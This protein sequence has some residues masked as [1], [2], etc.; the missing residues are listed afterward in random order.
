M[1]TL[2]YNKIRQVEGYLELA[3]M[4]TGKNKERMLHYA[5]EI[6]AELAK[7]KHLI[8]GWHKR[9]FAQRIEF[10]RIKLKETSAAAR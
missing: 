6:I 3:Q 1:T 8:A 9:D 2:Y 5:V 4:A 7:K 10:W